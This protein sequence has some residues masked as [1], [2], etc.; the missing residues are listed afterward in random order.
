ME[1]LNVKLAVEETVLIDN[2]GKMM[3]VNVNLVKLIVLLAKMILTVYHVQYKMT[4]DNSILQ[5]VLL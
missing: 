2:I 5:D 3:N 4:I 1:I